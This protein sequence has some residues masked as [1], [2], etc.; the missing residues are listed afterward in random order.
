[1]RTPYRHLNHK[2]RQLNQSTFMYH[3]R[4]ETADFCFE[5]SNVSA[6]QS[7]DKSS[8]VVSNY[9]KIRQKIDLGWSHPFSVQQFYL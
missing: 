3:L 9:Y 6:I 5:D 2:S 7:C 8:H 4:S 1:M